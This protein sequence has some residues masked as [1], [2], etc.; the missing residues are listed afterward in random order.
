[1]N[2][3][4]GILVLGLLIS[5]VA[6]VEY[7]SESLIYA[8]ESG[9]QINNANI[10]TSSAAPIVNKI[11]EANRLERF[12]ELERYIINDYDA[13][14]PFS[15]FLP[16]V[17]G[18][19]GKPLWSF[20]V[21]RGQGISSFGV[22]SKDYPLMEFFTA[23]EAYQ[24]T[25]LLGFRTFYQGYRNS[26]WGKV[27]ESFVLEP[28]DAARSR[29]EQIQDKS[30]LPSRQMYI[31]SNEVQIREVD[32]VNRIET[33]V[34]YFTLP[35]ENFGAFVRRTTIANTDKDRPLYISILDGLARM[36]P[37]G[38]KLDIL[39]KTIGRTL[40][41][42]KGLDQA[43]HGTMPFYRMSTE[44][45]D[46]ASVVYEEGG[47]FVL[48]FNENERNNLLPIVYD[49]SKV[50]GE[51]KSLS[52]PVGL[53]SKSIADIVEGPQ[54]G[55]ARTSSAFAAVRDV[56]IYPGQS[57]TIASFYG[58]ARSISDVPVIA[59][60]IVQGG[61][62]RYKLTRAREL[63]TQITASV[64]TRTAS[65]AFNAH[66]QQMYL[67]NSLRGGVPVLLGEIDDVSHSQNADEDARL[68]P[69]HLFSRIHGDLERDYNCES[70]QLCVCQAFLH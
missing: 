4:V 45:S 56:V 46:A 43:D 66:V 44:P 13:K 70:P 55:A 53:Y 12:D 14:P 18:I 41:G 69:Y 3:S 19:Y 22:K 2:L 58:K 39:L 60:R 16:A 68:K 30:S 49:T 47:H 35:E 32:H 59:R 17:A 34:T 15:N 64:E 33:N 31:G 65:K 36:Q 25:H 42:Y 24:N 11:K 26:G 8:G 20:Y 9:Q 38:G 50:F 1:M 5:S 51:D 10:T 48:S 54:Y 61:F 21:N 52:R 27:S 57:I 7:F 40:E 29:F 62:A 37:A 67:D 28:F 63:I 6:I 23:N